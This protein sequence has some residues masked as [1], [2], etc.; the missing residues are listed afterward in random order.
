MA[1]SYSKDQQICATCSCWGGS[2]KAHPCG[3]YSEVGV[4]QKGQCQRGIGGY[5]GT[6]QYATGSCNDWDKWGPL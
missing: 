3:I 2:R 6:Q 5:H 1:T 4:N